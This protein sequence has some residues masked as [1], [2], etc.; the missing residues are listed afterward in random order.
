MILDVK[1]TPNAKEDS[2]IEEADC[3]RIRT[4]APADKGKANEAVLKI[5]A[6]HYGVRMSKVR[7]LRGMRSRN[8]R[9]EIMGRDAR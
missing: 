5:I 9:V 2:L 7:L 4:R 8:K 3:L 1:V 6:G